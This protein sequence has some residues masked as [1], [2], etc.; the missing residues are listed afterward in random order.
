MTPDRGF[1][2]ADFSRETDYYLSVVDR[3][4]DLKHKADIR[5]RHAAL[6]NL[7]S[8]YYWADDMEN[9]AKYAQLLLRNG[10]EKNKAEADLRLIS[11][12][13]NEFRRSGIATRHFSV[14]DLYSYDGHGNDSRQ[15]KSY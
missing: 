9:A 12:T 10:F 14:Y 2:I 7:F 4:N 8:I 15:G 5:L 11:A 3:Y 6:H 1:D 13:E